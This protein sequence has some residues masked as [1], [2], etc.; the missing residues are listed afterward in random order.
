MII[1]GKHV[2][3][4]MFLRGVGSAIAL[5]L[6]ASMTPAFA[7]KTSAKPPTRV[8]FAYVPN[9]IIM[10]HWRPATTGADFELPRILEPLKP[11]KEQ[12]VLLS[13]LTQNGGRALGDGPGDHARAAA[14]FLTGVHPRKTAGSDMRCGVSVD[15][16]AAKALGSQ[17]R[18]ASLELGCEDGRLVGNC[19]SGYSCAYSNSIS[20]RGEA[21]PMPP[22]VNPRIVFE[23]LFGSVDGAESPAARNRRQQ[24]RKSIL[25]FVNEDT[26][27][28]Q[29]SLGPTDRRKLDEYL[30]GI[31]EIEKRIEAAEATA[32]VAPPEMEVPDGVPVDFAEHVKLMFDL[33]L[34]AFQTD[35]TRIATFMIG[36]EGSNR[37]YREI[38]VPDPHHGISH[39]KGDPVLIKKVAQ[40]NRYHVEQFSYFVGKLAS[41]P[42]G[43]GTL[44]DHSIIVY[45][46]GISDGNR[47]LHHDLPV[48]VFGKGSGAWKPGR[49]I[50]YPRDT[51]MA[52]L[53]LTML[54]RI[55]VPAESIGDS[56]GKLE[57]LT[58]LS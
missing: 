35:S 39:H 16:V 46:S 24:Y 37:T 18:F 13:G 10:N 2:P 29:A 12:M 3:R 21:T 54:D 55:G 1:T 58:D 42:D 22:E 25:D 31:R 4:R 56:T 19:D 45:G 53:Y 44:L 27:Q 11:H 15:Q 34:A 17:T 9:G 20:W 38:G 28:L 48:A 7:A 43:D 41:T 49:H 26:K 5:P 30:F 14:S 33:M 8:A 47:H 51:P 52:N 32:R 23:R 36:R 6:L 57:H 40:I 50:A